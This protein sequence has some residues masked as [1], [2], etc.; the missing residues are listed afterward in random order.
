MALSFNQEEDIKDDLSSSQ[1]EVVYCI[2]EYKDECSTQNTKIRAS[3]SFLSLLFQFLILLVV[4]LLSLL[5]L[6][7]EMFTRD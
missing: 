3:L 4:A 2:T 7:S 1:D 5:H 6:L